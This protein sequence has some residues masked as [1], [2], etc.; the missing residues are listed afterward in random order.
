MFVRDVSVTCMHSTALAEC[1]S[2]CVE[3]PGL[4]TYAALG[5]AQL[6]QDNAWRPKLD[7]IPMNP[8]GRRS[9]HPE[10]HSR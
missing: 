6:I 1:Q 4:S 3:V 10:M 8:H 5:T 7:A 2:V 9:D